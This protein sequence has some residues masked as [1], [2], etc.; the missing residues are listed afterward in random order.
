MANELYAIS[1]GKHPQAETNLSI[2]VSAQISSVGGGFVV[3]ISLN[4]V[5][6]PKIE[7]HIEASAL[8]WK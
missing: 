8:K 7:T 6:R 1:S 5:V 4:T 2:A 3:Y